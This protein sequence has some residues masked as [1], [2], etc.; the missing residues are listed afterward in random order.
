MKEL[1]LMPLQM[2]F[3]SQCYYLVLILAVDPRMIISEPLALLFGIPVLIFFTL[4]Y[5]LLR[6]LCPHPRHFFY[7]LLVTGLLLTSGA[8]VAVAAAFDSLLSWCE[9]Y[10]LI[11]FVLASMLSAFLGI[12]YYKGR[13][14]GGRSD[15]FE[16]TNIKS[17]YDAH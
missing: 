1:L 12:I 5:A 9:W 16:S 10:D 17:P 15:H 13:I 7:G 4:S 8:T 3:R 11:P 6:W 2:W 14:C